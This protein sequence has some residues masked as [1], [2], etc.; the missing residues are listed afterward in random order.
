M[1][2]ISALTSFI[3][4]FAG[5]AVVGPWWVARLRRRGYVY[6]W[7][8]RWRTLGIKKVEVGR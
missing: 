5:A 4:A 2:W 1:I 3:G 8:G 6:V 7:T